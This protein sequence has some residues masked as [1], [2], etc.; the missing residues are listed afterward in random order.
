[1]EHKIIDYDGLSK[2]ELAA[3]LAR[4]ANKEG[5][6]PV[7]P[8]PGTTWILLRSLAV[9]EFSIQFSEARPAVLPIPINLNFPV[10]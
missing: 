4:L 8:I 1:M 10:G 6:D 5:W 2:E 7:F 3:E 9:P